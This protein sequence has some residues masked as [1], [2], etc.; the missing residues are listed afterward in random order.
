MLIVVADSHVLPGTPSEGAFRAFLQWIE[1]TDYDI[2]FLGDI[3]ELWIGLPQY[4]T[5]L[6]QWFAQWC[7]DQCAHRHI[8]F[9]EGNHEYFV[10]RHHRDCFTASS[11]DAL[12]LPQ[13]GLHLEHGDDFAGVASRAH[14]RFRWWCKSH[15]AHFLLN[16][17]P[18]AA[19]FV[20]YLK[21][22][23]EHSAKI[24]KYRFEQARLST[25]AS[26]ALRADGVHAVLYGHFHR[27]YLEHRRNSQLFAVLPA[28][29]KAGEIGIYAP[30][31]NTLQIM[32]W[33]DWA[34]KNKK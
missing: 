25:E 31:S 19:A 11:P 28:W 5:P 14:R 3:M 20:R 30:Q 33:Q 17:L 22:K 34:K 16:W 23:L 12:I 21:R 8:Y 6:Q 2:A 26:K 27:E 4:E 29:K 7:H 18:G 13:Y 32:P 1:S 9:V 10:L 15:L 24:R